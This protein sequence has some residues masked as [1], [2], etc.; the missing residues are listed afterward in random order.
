MWIRIQLNVRVNIFR[1]NIHFYEIIIIFNVGPWLDEG[2]MILQNLKLPL[3]FTDLTIDER[4]DL[5]KTI[6]HRTGSTRRS[7]RAWCEYGNQVQEGHKTFLTRLRENII[8][9]NEVSEIL[10]FWPS[11]RSK[12]MRTQLA[13]K[14]TK[15][16]V[17]NVRV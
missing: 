1:R 2:H 12:G 15:Y 6:C 16:V 4:V 3:K 13:R 11:S 17:V 14:I 5:F 7:I 8:E 9:G 10:I